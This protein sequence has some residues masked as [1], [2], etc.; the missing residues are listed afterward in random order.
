MKEMFSNVPDKTP[1]VA[2][3][4]EYRKQGLG[5]LAA[6]RKC[7]SPQVHIP[8]Y[9]DRN[10]GCMTEVCKKQKIRR[11]QSFERSAVTVLVSCFF[12]FLFKRQK[13]KR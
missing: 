13:L 12:F 2:P 3:A 7:F 10:L 11:I 1:A 5:K 9:E 6:W 8:M 4:N